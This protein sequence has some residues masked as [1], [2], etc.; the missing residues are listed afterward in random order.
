M[1]RLQTPVG[2]RIDVTDR[3]FARLE[4]FLQPRPRSTRYLRRRSAASA[5]ARSTPAMIFVTLKDPASARAIPKTGAA[6]ASRSSWTSCAARGQRDPGHPRRSSRT[7]RSRGSAAAARLSRRVHDPRPRLGR[8]RASH[9]RD[10]GGACAQTG[11][12]TDVDSDYQVGMPEVQVIP[13]RDKAADLGRQHGRHRRDHERRHRRRARGQVRGRRPPL[14]HPRAPARRRSASA[15]RT[16]SAS[17]CAATAASWCRWATSCASSR[18]RGLQA[19]TRKDRERAITV[20]ANVAP[21]RLAGRR[22][23]PSLRDRAARILP[24][25]YRAVLVRQRADVPGVVPS[26]CSS[27]FV[28]GIIVA[29]MVLATQFNTFI[30]P[31]TV[32]LALPFSVS[33][34]APRA[35]DRRPVAEHL[36][37]A[38][39]H[40]AD[41]HREE[42]LDPARGLHEPG[43]RAGGDA[44]ARRC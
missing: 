12:V 24:E 42:E 38:R 20:F 34:R 31:F 37:H 4:E 26:P 22:H 35:L 29:Y 44:R 27:R 17:W 43:A 39:P 28:L 13:D 36:Q 30:H 10:H 21:G 32:L 25:G 40:P 19:I 8:A 3:A 33:G 16:S 2:S 14:R 11:L 5:A 23:R 9:P 18:A 6:S 15:P 7:S 1:V 41:G